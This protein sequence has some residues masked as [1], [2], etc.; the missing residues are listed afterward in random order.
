M[1][2]SKKSAMELSLNLIIMLVIG[3][4]VL[5]TVIFFVRGQ[6]GG[7]SEGFDKYSSEQNKEALEAFEKNCDD[8]I[9]I[10]P[11]VEMKAKTGEPQRIYLYFRAIGDSNIDCVPG[12]LVGQ[13]C[14]ISFE[15][16]GTDN[17]DY[18]NSLLIIGPGFS[19]NSE[20]AEGNSNVY[21]LEINGVREGTYFLTIKLYPG[22]IYEEKKVITLKVE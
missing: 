17:T 1:V 22:E 13:N 6:F 18:T 10:S 11:D 9:C 21:D 15:I 2:K 19:L 3:G 12:D 16:V 8:N 4:V 20:I 7:L 5:A 14:E